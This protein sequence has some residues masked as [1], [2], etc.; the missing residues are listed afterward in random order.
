MVAFLG[1]ILSVFIGIVFLCKVFGFSIF[2]EKPSGLPNGSMGHF[3]F[4]GETLAYLKPHHSNSLGF[5]L[6][7]HCSR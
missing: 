2:K 7:D 6:Q 3:P 4:L 5:F 1:V